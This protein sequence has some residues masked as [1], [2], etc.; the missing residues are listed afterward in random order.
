MLY[1]SQDVGINDTVIYFDPDTLYKSLPSSGYVW[2]HSDDDNHELIYYDD[3][4]SVNN[5]LIRC[6]RG[7]EDTEAAEHLSG[8]L[9]IRKLTNLYYW[10]YH[11]TDIGK[12]HTFKAQAFTVYHF[13]AD[14]DDSPTDTIFINGYSILPYPPGSLK[15]MYDGSPFVAK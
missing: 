2:L 14:F 9:I 5:C 15:A 10:N 7:C 4:D 12:T 3:I 1:I 8:D 11:Q 6:T 13:Y